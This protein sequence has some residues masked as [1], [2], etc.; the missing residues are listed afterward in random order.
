MTS[1]TEQH[2]A[3]DSQGFSYFA[4]LPNVANLETAPWPYL[5]WA[6]LLD[7]CKAFVGCDNDDDNMRQLSL[8][9]DLMF[10]WNAGHSAEGI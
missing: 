8:Q 10:G 6:A 4:I 9:G 2:G 7:L 5:R 3:D 1:D